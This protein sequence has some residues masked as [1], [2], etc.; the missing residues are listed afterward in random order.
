MKRLSKAVVFLFAGL[1]IAC[2]AF[3]QNSKKEQKQEEIKNMMTNGHYI[4]EADY[5]IP[6]SGAG[7][8]LTSLYDLKISKDSVIAYLPY[9]GRAYLAPNPG[10]DLEGGIKFS[11]A[12]F[13]YVQK[14]SK[15]GSWEISIKPKDTNLTNWRDVQQMQLDV[16]ANGYASLIVIS[17]NRD[18]IT[19]NGYIVDKE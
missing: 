8:Q 16:S 13:N 1:A 5:A 9:F 19:F 7:R 6:Q 11:T 12:N 10:D 14:Q 18:A 2:S 4:F 3:A 15:K 17:S